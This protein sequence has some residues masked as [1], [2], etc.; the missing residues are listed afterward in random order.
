MRTELDQYIIDRIREKRIAI[1]M[2]QEVLAE[3]MGFRSN[4]FIAAA[5]SPKSTKKYNP[6]H[7][8]KAALIFACSLWDLLPKDPIVNN[9][10]FKPLLRKKDSA[11]INSK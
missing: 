1:R 9:K 6:V 5:E 11:N 10:T 2:S 7:M 3:K 8:N 4:A